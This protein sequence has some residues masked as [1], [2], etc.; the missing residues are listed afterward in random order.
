[1]NYYCLPKISLNQVFKQVKDLSWVA[2]KAPFRFIIA[3]SVLVQ[4]ER[5]HLSCKTR[6]DS[7]TIFRTSGYYSPVSKEWKGK[8]GAVTWRRA[9]LPENEVY[10]DLDDY[11]IDM[12]TAA[13]QANN[14]AFHYEKYF[15]AQ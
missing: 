1:M 11:A 7:S 13:F 15:K 2:G 4:I 12:K 3:D 9:N 10:A 14:V 8:G 5:F 6:N